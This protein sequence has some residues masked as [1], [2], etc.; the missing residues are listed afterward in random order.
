[1]GRAD[2]PEVGSRTTSADYVLHTM[3]EVEQFLRELADSMDE[4]ST[5]NG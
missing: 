1:V 5:A 4:P 3:Q 2:D